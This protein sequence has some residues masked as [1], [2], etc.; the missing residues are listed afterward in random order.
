MH[1]SGGR[2]T[3]A[4]AVRQTHHHAGSGMPRSDV[5]AIRGERIYRK[6]DHQFY[7]KYVGFDEYTWEPAG[8]ILEQVADKVAAYWKRH[9]AVNTRVLYHV[10]T[11]IGTGEDW[12]PAE[13][14]RVVHQWIYL[15]EDSS[16]AEKEKQARKRARPAEKRIQVSNQWVFDITG[17]DSNSP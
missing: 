10:P 14:I 3:R 7:V 9:P 16:E 8:T 11:S 6:T 17:T 1:G 15:E 12:R 2:R 4:R 13:V 5:E